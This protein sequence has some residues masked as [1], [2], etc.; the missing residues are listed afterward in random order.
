MSRRKD[1][2]SVILDIVQAHLGCLPCFSR[3]PPSPP[4]DPLEGELETL[5][6][7]P[8]DFSLKVTGRRRISDFSEESE[9]EGDHFGDARELDERD[10]QTFLG[11]LEPGLSLADIE[12]EEREEA[13]RQ[14][15]A[16]GRIYSEGGER[17]ED[18]FGGFHTATTVTAHQ[19]NTNEGT[20]EYGSDGDE[21]AEVS[22]ALGAENDSDIDA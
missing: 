22:F 10:V 9:Q 6:G 1:L 15:R 16:M 18:E 11:R 4:L 19:R 17:G 5:L 8:S 3:R 20:K 13:E 14:E 12:R 2:I 21:E 7:G